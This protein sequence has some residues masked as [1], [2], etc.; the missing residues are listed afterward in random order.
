MS[1]ENQHQLS[2]LSEIPLF[3]SFL[4]KDV[5]RLSGVTSLRWVSSPN[6][7][8]RRIHLEIRA[9]LSNLKVDMPYAT[10]GAKKSKVVD[11]VRRH[12][13]NQYVCTY[14]LKA[15]YEHVRPAVMAHIL[16]RHGVP[17]AT[18]KQI[19]EYCFHPEG[20]LV[21]GGLVATQLFNLYAAEV[22]DRPL[23]SLLGERGNITYT[24][25]LDDL[26]F[27]SPAPIGRRFRRQIL[28]I[29]RSASFDIQPAKAKHV[30]LVSEP[31]QSVILN[32]VGL[33][34]NG[35]MYVPPGFR[36]LLYQLLKKANAGEAIDPSTV[37]GC[38]GAF[39]AIK[40]RGSLM[41]RS[42]QKVAFEYRKYVR[43][44][45]LA[46]RTYRQRKAEKQ[47]RYRRR[48]RLKSSYFRHGRRAGP[49]ARQPARRPYDFSF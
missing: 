25:Y 4:V 43:G 18:I 34:L 5:N 48:R 6:Q 14:D 37:H 32:G 28:Q 33:R 30:D 23:A 41:T 12:R 20:G 40:R 39:F 27:S 22:L 35:D 7:A 13:G 49:V 26:I 45:R 15:A 29:I 42:E 1:F 38:V 46:D 24:R 11:H 47:R 44:Q 17:G 2:L 31:N 3:H 21:T 16:R 10:A 36:E 8:M 9:E 19:Q